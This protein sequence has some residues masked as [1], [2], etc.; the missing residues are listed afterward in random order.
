MTNTL[1]DAQDRLWKSIAAAGK[2]Q[3][4]VAIETAASIRTMILMLEVSA[5]C[6]LEEARKYKPGSDGYRVCMMLA[7]KFG[8]DAKLIKK[9]A[10]P[11]RAA[12]IIAG[13]HP[14]PS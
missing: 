11:D 7:A 13:A 10:S 2:D 8:Q 3:A 5:G 14:K 1:E 9:M 4:T 12:E 6:C